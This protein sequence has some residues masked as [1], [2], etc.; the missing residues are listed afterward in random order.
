MKPACRPA[1]SQPPQIISFLPYFF[2]ISS[3]LHGLE[4]IP[5][6]N[7]ELKPIIDE[8]LAASAVMNLD[9]QSFPGQDHSA[10]F[11]KRLDQLPEHFR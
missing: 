11:K 6:G 10:A 5:G 4:R 9:I 8:I 1:V 3:S 7:A 2:L